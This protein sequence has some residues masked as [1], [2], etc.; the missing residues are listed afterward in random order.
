MWLKQKKDATKIRFLWQDLLTKT[1][2]SSTVDSSHL[3]IMR[4]MRLARA[5]RGVRVMR[6][7]RFIGALRSIVFAIMSHLDSCNKQEKNKSPES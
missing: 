7:V 6:L 2:E 4:F 1:M 3:R 5:L